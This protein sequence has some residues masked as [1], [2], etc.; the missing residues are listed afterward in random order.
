MVRGR[1]GA[2][3]LV[4][5]ALILAIACGGGG[6]GGSSSTTGTTTSGRPPVA[7]DPTCAAIVPQAVPT[8]A[9]MQSRFG[10]NVIIPPSS[11]PKP[12]DSGRAH[13]N[14][15]IL[16][17]PALSRA[18]DPSGLTPAQLH[19]AYGIPNGGSGAIAIV[20]AFNY[21]TALNDFNV[22]ASQF[23]LPQETSSSVTSTSNTVFRV[24]YASGSKPTDDASWSQEMALDIDCAHAMA[25]NAKIYLVEAASDS[26]DDLATAVTVAKKLSGV[27]EVSLS[28]GSVETSCMFVDYDSRFLQSGVVFFA[29]AGDDAPHRDFP[30]ESKN[31][32]SVGGTTL[33]VA[34]DGT[35][36]NE[37]AWDGTACGPSA[38]EPRP[39]F[40]DPFF[41]LT[42][43]FRGACDISAVGDP[44]T[45]VSIYDSTPFS[46]QSGWQVFGGTSASCPIIAGCANVS[47]SARTSSQSQNTVLYSNIGTANFHDITS[48]SASGFNAG[49][50]WDFPTGV[51]SPN[52]TGGF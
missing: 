38:F 26:L 10:P 24:V 52:G 30:G 35:W 11:V 14:H 17:R 8:L 13:T 50:G 36:I 21:P 20:D 12:I 25:P 37:S 29:S 34:P 44:L 41:N 28:F 42:G 23:G 18:P 45:G 6:G 16:N 32:V 48:G 7:P 39:I 27:K 3:S 31:V 5:I 15:L 47:G 46:G 9:Q 40:Q 4:G 49:P 43:E 33:T 19:K 2:V 1:A 51:G 22:F